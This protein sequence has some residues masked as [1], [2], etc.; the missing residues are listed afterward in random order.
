MATPGGGSVRTP[1]LTPES[2]WQD[3]QKLAQK[4]PVFTKD[5]YI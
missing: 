3:M 2:V 1:G 4:G 5:F